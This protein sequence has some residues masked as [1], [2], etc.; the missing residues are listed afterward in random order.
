M[1]TTHRPIRSS[2]DLRGRTV[3]VLG[4]ARS[5]LAAARFLADAGAIVT[6]YDRRG[7]DEL[8]AAV[9]ELGGRD[10]RLALGS[11]P[12][13]ATRLIAA[14]DLLVT[15]PSISPRFPTTDPWLRAALQ[16]AEARGAELI[17][18]HFFPT[19]DERLEH[20]RFGLNRL[21]IPK[22]AGF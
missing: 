17:P 11:S 8:A 20:D 13:D 1:M 3:L 16:E 5:G 12:G 7:P 4:L 14:S 15:S 9:A 21:G 22:S 18:K 6:T 10:I 2:G 19:D